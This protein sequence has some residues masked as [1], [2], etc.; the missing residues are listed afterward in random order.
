M[1][2][3]VEIRRPL[4][5]TLCTKNDMQEYAFDI[6]SVVLCS[7]LYLG[8]L[9]AYVLYSRRAPYFFR[10]NLVNRTF[11]DNLSTSVV[12]KPYINLII[13]NRLIQSPLE[14]WQAALSHNPEVI[15]QVLGS[16]PE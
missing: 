6:Q 3:N 8:L 10:S 12:Q 5:P 4:R 2:S 16:N 14:Q 13:S 15:L 11:Y 7:P 1:Q 9:G